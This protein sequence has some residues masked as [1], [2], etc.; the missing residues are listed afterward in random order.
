MEEEYD[1]KVKI[2]RQKREEER[3]EKDRE[4]RRKLREGKGQAGPQK[5]SISSLPSIHGEYLR[6]PRDKIVVRAEVKEG[7][8][9]FYVKGKNYC[10]NYVRLV[11]QCPWV[12]V[13]FSAK[14]SL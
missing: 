11:V 12:A 1:E 13:E 3:K 2:E 7:A 9:F 4:E 10:P 6:R 5:K 14:F 8:S